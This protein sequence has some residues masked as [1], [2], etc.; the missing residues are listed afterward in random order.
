LKDEDNAKKN[1]PAGLFDDSD[2]EKEMKANK[3]QA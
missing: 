1:L 2:D 3:K